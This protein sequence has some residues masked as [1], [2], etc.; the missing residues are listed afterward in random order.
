MAT[1]LN[2]PSS[3]PALFFPG[4]IVCNSYEVL[5]FLGIGSSGVVYECRHKELN[6]HPVAMKVFSAQAARSVEEIERF[7][8]E[9]LAAYQV[10]HPNV[11]RGYELITTKEFIAFTME[12]V[13]GGSLADR[14][15]LHQQLE[16]KQVVD[17]MLAICAG[18][19]GIHG[20][21]I[22]HRDLKPGNILITSEGNI[23]IAD[24]G[25]SYSERASRL[26]PE[27]LVGTV[28]YVSPEYIRDG[29]TDA[30]SDLYSLGVIAYEMLAGRVPFEGHTAFQTLFM[31]LERDAER[32]AKYR[33]DCPKLLSEIIARALLR[34]PAERYQSATEMKKDVLA[35]QEQML[36]KTH[37]RPKQEIRSALLPSQAALAKRRPKRRPSPLPL[38]QRSHFIH[39]FAATS[40]MFW[41][42]TIAVWFYY[43]K[44]NSLLASGNTVSG[45][46]RTE[47]I[48][49]RI[50]HENL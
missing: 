39:A 13:G 43:G 44:Y 37:L 14:I 26:N 8:H 12:F 29:K 41:L 40:L 21:G 4:S 38:Y 33:E 32:V 16:L 28:E 23:K 46:F 20:S 25:I 48:Q 49:Y 5:R 3:G 2:P 15:S 31:R 18:L 34:N 27:K 19:E 22:V 10:N 24:F 1:Q 35:L 42:A 17:I 50:P 11:V 45:T 9:L 6:N 36:H 7:K 47:N 30:R